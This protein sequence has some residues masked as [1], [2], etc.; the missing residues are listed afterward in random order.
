MGKTNNR[1]KG[2]A[3]KIETKIVL[4]NKYES[5]SKWGGFPQ[6]IKNRRHNYK[7]CRVAFS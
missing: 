1:T 5:Y 7:R 2:K 4:Q 3:K 6:I